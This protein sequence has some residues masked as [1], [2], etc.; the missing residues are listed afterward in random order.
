M[1]VFKLSGQLRQHD[2]AS[3]TFFFEKDHA[4]DNQKDHGQ[5]NYEPGYLLAYFFHFRIPSRLIA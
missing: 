4:K 1:S 3:G 2:I 5:H